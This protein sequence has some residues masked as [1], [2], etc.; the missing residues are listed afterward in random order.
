MSAVDPGLCAGCRQHRVI[1]GAHSDFWMCRRSALDARFP[2]YPRLPVLSCVGYDPA[3][4]DK[5]P[6]HEKAPLDR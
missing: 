2:R 5:G 4:P 1:K 6:N 3:P